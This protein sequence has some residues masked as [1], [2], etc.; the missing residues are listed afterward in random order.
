MNFANMFSVNTEE[1]PHHQQ[2]FLCTLLA[3]RKVRYTSLQQEGCQV[4]ISG[5]PFPL[6]KS[7]LGAW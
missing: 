6:W 4:K 1:K 3:V 5:G 7:K 2:Q